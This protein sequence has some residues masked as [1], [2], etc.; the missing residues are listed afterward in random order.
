MKRT[1]F[2]SLV[3][4]ACV[5]APRQEAQPTAAPVAAAPVG[6]V[7]GPGVTA[8]GE[9]VPI[10]TILANVDAWDGKRVRVEGTVS[11]VCQNRGCWIDIAGAAPG[12]L[13]RMKVVDGEITF[14]PAAK[15]KRVVAEGIVR[16]LA[17][18]PAPAHSCEGEEGHDC[19]AP[20]Q[21]TARLEGIGA[22]IL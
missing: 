7:Y 17:G 4:M 1:L 15:G 2:L 13:L 20:P 14:P 3:L 10:K 9:A 22:V 11:G 18:A 6:T 21:A 12:E 5:Q 19:S 16:K 8:G